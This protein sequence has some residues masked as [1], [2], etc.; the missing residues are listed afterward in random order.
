MAY[1]IA[2]TYVAS[3]NCK[4][5]CPCPV[6]GPPTGADDQC[7]GAAV[8]TIR[9]G[10]LDDV[11]LSGVNF[12]FYNLFPSNLSAG[13]WK[14]GIVVDEGA[15]DEQAR[16]LEQILSG[17][18]GGPFGE[19]APLFGE[20]LGMER[21]SVTFSDGDA[22]SG[23]VAGKTSITFEPFRGLDGSPTTEKNA[24]FGFAPEFGIGRTSGQSNAFG[25]S[26]DANYGELADYMF[27]TEAEATTHPRA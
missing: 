10:N 23:E 11:D 6:D 22:P 16:A 5:I 21:A 4:L 25:L 3:C 15:S 8:F 12:G 24:M 19:F 17:Q 14:V 2:G 7:T 27:S 20:Y 18:A 9:E 26:F 1:T 13:N